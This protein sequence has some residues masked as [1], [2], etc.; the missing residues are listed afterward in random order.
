VRVRLERN[1]FAGAA[2]FHDYIYQ[3]ERI[4]KTLAG[5]VGYE[6][7]HMPVDSQLRSLIAL[8][9]VNAQ[10]TGYLYDCNT[11]GLGCDLNSPEDDDE[12]PDDDWTI[13]DPDPGGEVTPID[14]DVPID[15]GGGGGSVP[16]D[17][18]ED[19]LPE[20][21]PNP[22]DEVDG[23]E[24]GIYFHTATWDA[25]VLTVRMR[26]APTG[27]APRDDLGALDV[28]IASTS[29]V[30]L[31]P[32]GSLANPQPETLPSVSFT[33][34]IAEPWDAVAEGTPLPPSDRIFEG[35]FVITFAG[36]AFP[37][38]AEDP[39]E[40]L[41]YRATVEFTDWEGGFTD[42][43]FLNTLAV[44]F[45]P[46]EPPPEPEPPD[47]DGVFIY[48][49][50][51]APPLANDEGAVITREASAI[52]PYST[53]E[54]DGFT[55]YTID[56]EEIVSMIGE[57]WNVDFGETEIDAS[58]G[59]FTVQYLVKQEGSTGTVRIELFNGSTLPANTRFDITTYSTFILAS[60][61][62]VNYDFLNIANNS[63]SYVYYAIQK[64]SGNKI[65][66]H[67]NGQKIYDE[68][69]S[70]S[71][72]DIL[73]FRLLR[74]ASTGVAISPIRIE[75][76]AVYGDAE[77]IEPLPYPFCGPLESLTP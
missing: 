50:S 35:Q 69:T 17:G 20:P 75:D 54:G 70:A 61:D 57:A 47:C 58:T 23:Y 59:E 40:Q 28:T 27:K 63:S 45:V 52:E 21:D 25:N 51:T 9:V 48:F 53:V 5:D 10:G 13:P 18:G 74:D 34:Q 73:R 14:P 46:T 44:D 72:P 1:P 12:I 38:A 56:A 76:R 30:A 3:V 8:D 33:G 66:V 4:T 71:S 31:L 49:P 43:S 2:A 64:I 29:V 42:V 15:I 68:S 22:D 7:S 36:S 19:G 32:N 41:T 65:T 55:A 24:A 60:Q 39:A 26:L 11:T 6:C 62:G 67:R 16:G 77:T 37:P